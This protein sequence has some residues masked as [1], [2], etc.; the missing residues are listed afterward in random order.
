MI[1][2]TSSFC[3]ASASMRTLPRFSPPCSR[4][5]CVGSPM[6]SMP[7]ISMCFRSS[8]CLPPPFLNRD[9]SKS[10]LII[11]RLRNPMK[12]NDL[13]DPNAQDDQREAFGP[14]TCWAFQ[15]SCQ[16]L[17]QYL[18]RSA[19]REYV[20]CAKRK[21]RN[22]NDSIC[23]QPLVSTIAENARLYVRRMRT[24][25]CLI[26]LRPTQRSAAPWRKIQNEN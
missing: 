4:T 26:L 6:P 20:I 21:R 11:N 23:S 1:C 13:S 19:G 15:P 9:G 7:R 17:L 14:S 8:P 24:G 3:L 2:L 22:S 12:S 16:N 25:L 5:N 18:A 10:G